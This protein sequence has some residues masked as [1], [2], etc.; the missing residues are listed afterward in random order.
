MSAGDTMRAVTQVRGVTKVQNPNRV[1]I[2]AMLAFTDG[3]TTPSVLGANKFRTANT[4]ATAITDFDDV[5]DDGYKITVFF[6]DDL[7]TITHNNSVI[8]LPGSLSRQFL[9]GDIMEFL[10]RNGVWYGMEGRQD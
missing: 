9:T 5:T 3:D 2:S 1:E 6:G 8:D 7:T 10:M 4:G